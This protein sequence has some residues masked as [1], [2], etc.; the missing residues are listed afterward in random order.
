MKTLRLNY[1]HIDMNN[2]LS[3]PKILRGG[4]PFNY[5]LKAF[6][7]LTGRYYRS[8]FFY[9]FIKTLCVYNFC[10]NKTMYELMSH[11]SEERILWKNI[12]HIHVNNVVHV[13]DM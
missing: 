1:N 3:M 11:K 8:V 10:Y 9:C 12:A 6:T 7:V 13:A 2:S 4:V 5:N